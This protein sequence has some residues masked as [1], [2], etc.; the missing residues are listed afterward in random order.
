MYCT[1]A[2]NMPANFS[3]FPMT[4]EQGRRLCRVMTRASG[5]YTIGILEFRESVP[6]IAELPVTQSLGEHGKL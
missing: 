4:F 5:R 2:R 6:A 3:H 1:I